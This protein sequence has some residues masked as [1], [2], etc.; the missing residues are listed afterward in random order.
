MKRKK[1]MKKY[2][3]VLMAIVLIFS[4]V[5]VAA[6][7][8]PFGTGSGGAARVGAG[9]NGPVSQDSPRGNVLGLNGL[10]GLELTEQQRSEIR[11]MLQLYQEEVD[12]E[13]L[14]N[15]ERVQELREAHVAIM[16]DDVFDESAA[17][18]ILVER[19]E[20]NLARQIIR[21][22]LQ[23]QILYDI[24]DE[25]QREQLQN[26]WQNQIA[27]SDGVGQGPGPGEGLGDCPYM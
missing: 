23:H 22:R 20:L 5:S 7:A 25:E 6:V 11:N 21:Q 27:F 24:L 8:Q 3:V 1:I 12:A 26:Q 17:L 14:N 15:R 10:M 4:F 16:E 9:G 2:L 13:R 19:A 18:D